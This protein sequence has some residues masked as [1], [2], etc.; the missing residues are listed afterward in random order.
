MSYL[1]DFTTANTAYVYFNTFDSNDPSASVT[2][3]GLAVTDIEI[4]KDGSVTQRSSD[5]GY[6]LLDTD[7]ID[8]DGTTGIHGFSIDL[9]DNTDAGFYAAG[10]EYVVVVSSVTV[11]AATVNFVAAT[12][13]IERTG[14]ALALLKGTNSLANIASNLVIIASDTVAIEV[15]TGTTL[16][17]QITTIAS[18]LVIVA[19]DI[20]VIDDLLDTEMAAQTS[21]LVIIAS[22]TAAIEVDTSTTLS[23]QVTTI[24]S[25]VVLIYSDTTVIEA[26][27]STPLAS[28]TADSGSTTTMVD[29]A[30][31]EADDNYWT[32]ARIQFTSGNID[33]Q[34]REITG[35]VAATDTIT[36]SPAVTQA[37]TTQT[38]NIIVGVAASGLSAAQDS[39]LTAIQ[40]DLT[41]AASDIIVIDDLL[42]TEMAAQTSNL[43]IIAS[44]TAAIEVDTGTTLSAQVTTIASDL[45]LAQADLDTIT[46]DTAA[47]EVD[48][49][50]TLSAQVTTIASDLVLA[51]ADLDTITSDTA[52][53]EV[54]TSTTLSAQVTTIASDL[55]LI[56]ADVVTI[57]DFLDTEMAAQTSNLV[58]IASDTAAIEV[59]TGTTL[60]AQVTTVASDLVLAQTDLDTLTA[61]VNVTQLNGVAAAAAGLALSADTIVNGTASGIPT[62]T[63]MVSDV[64]ITVDDQLKGRIIIFAD[65]T[66]TTALRDQATDITACT[67]SSNTLTFT[68]LTTAPVSGDTFVIV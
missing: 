8:F 36:F 28:G 47:I 41:V 31:T 38:Y 25:D 32:G 58:I 13:S 14:G 37:V 4:Y 5:A 66:T 60:S 35:F 61:G 40:L 22:D 34:V 30:R 2:L 33:G 52:A 62:T 54:D 15:D 20:I 44:D 16:S 1:G 55:V 39:T 53:I 3:T 45:V 59:D 46:S 63:T 65:N 67:A 43:V 27:P 7:G 56:A 11:D 48:T 17:A 6:T 19:S 50:T 42:D 51:Q 18:D 49:S 24:A 10:S 23:A 26:S 64:G 29:A 57:D 68:A 21:N 9:S 12:F